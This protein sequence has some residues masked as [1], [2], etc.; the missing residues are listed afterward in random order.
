[1]QKEIL[2]VTLNSTYQHAAFGLRYLYANLNELQCRSQILE[3]TIHASPRNIV[4]KILSY[5]PRIVGFGVYIWNTD[6]IAE[7]VSILKKVAPKITVVLGGPEV[8]YESEVQNICKAADYVIKGEADF[9]FYEF[10]SKVLADQ[11]PSDK[12][13][14]GPLPDISKINMPYSLY[15]DEDIANRVV[16]VE[17]SRGCPY[18]C[19]YCLSSLDKAVRNFNSNQFL[20]EMDGLIS[21]GLRQFK[22][23]DRTF[24]LSIEISSKILKFFLERVHFGLF[25]HFEM[26]PDR[27]PSELKELIKSF[28]EGSLQFE[29]G[30]QTW[31]PEVARNVS[32]RN[33]FVKVR[34][35]FEF[36]SSECGVH[37][38]ADLIVGLPGETLQ[39]FAKGFDEL[40]SCNP[41]EIQVGILKRLK[42]TPIVR[43]DQSFEMVYQEHPPFQ[44]LKTK[45][46]SYLEM[47]QMNRFSRFWDLIANSGNFPNFISWLK[48]QSRE[49]EDHSFFWEFFDLSVF[50]AGRFKETHGISLQSI[51]EA[52]WIYLIEVKNC[53]KD[54]ARDLLLSD[55]MRDKPRNVPSFLKEGMELTAYQLHQR[56]LSTRAIPQRQKRHIKNTLTKNT[57]V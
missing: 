41:H 12:F 53:Q 46:V 9:L 23:V 48:A 33:D 57:S 17:A 42:G 29:V 27:L 21:R 34:E 13:I 31:N 5:E 32:R 20:Q 7:V 25:L 37:T 3:W 15:N 19:E 2:L 6:E 24:N 28:P 18:K 56:A 16:Y 22:F 44:I 1:M 45:D 10:C 51:L 52:L 26:V 43:H 49:R 55:Y 35:N 36:L 50:L 11:K 38:H 8:S 39:S 47:Q 54:F 30:I 14:S 4:E 40:I